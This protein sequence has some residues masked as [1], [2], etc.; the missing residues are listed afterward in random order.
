MLANRGIHAR[1]VHL[2]ILDAVIP[3]HK[4]TLR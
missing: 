4:I 1:V 2:G 3:D